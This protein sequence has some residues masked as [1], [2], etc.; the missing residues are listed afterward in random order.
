LKYQE[1]RY[2]K[3]ECPTCKKT[4]CFE[5]CN[6]CGNDIKWNNYLGDPCYETNKQGKKVRYA[7]NKDDSV[8][9]C[10]EKGTK[11]YIN[12]T[13]V[14]EYVL[15]EYRTLRR[16][17]GPVFRCELCGRR[18]DLPWMLEFHLKD[19]KCEALL[20]EKFF[21]QPPTKVIDPNNHSLEEYK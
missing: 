8:H 10:M 5:H 13:E 3:Y 15:D 1:K 17:G 11:Q 7:F 19:A 16:W 6:N 20:M 2:K 4:E 12:T 9:K 18:A 21:K 14:N